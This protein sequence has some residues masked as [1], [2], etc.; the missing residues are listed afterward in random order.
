M[1]HPL[2]LLPQPALSAFFSPVYGVYIG[3]IAVDRA[4]KVAFGNTS[5]T[6]SLRR[7]LLCRI[8]ER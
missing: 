4:G 3:I 1:N 6:F 5:T 7:W 2:D 8:E